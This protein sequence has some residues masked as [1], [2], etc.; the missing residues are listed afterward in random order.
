M[1]HLTLTFPAAPWSPALFWISALGSLLLLG[2]GFAAWAV[3]PSAAAAHFVGTLVAAAPLVTVAGATLFVVRGFA[4]VDGELH[5]RRL[6]WTTRLSLSGLRAAGPDPTLLRGS[7]RTVGNGGL[8]SFS[9]RFYNRRTGSYRAFIT[10]WSRAV[11]LRTEA[12][13]IALSPDDPAAFT[14]SLRR[15]YPGLRELPADPIAAG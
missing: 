6:L 10:D 11:V 2:V 14:Q 13:A 3:I 1:R 15:L 12:G 9:G 7:L 5:V 8:Y 4:L